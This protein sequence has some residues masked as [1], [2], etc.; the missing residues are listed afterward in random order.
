MTIRWLTVLLVVLWSLFVMKVEHGNAAQARGGPHAD[1]SA[2][3]TEILEQLQASVKA[4]AVGDLVTLQATSQPVDPVDECGSN[5]RYEFNRRVQANGVV[6]PFQIPSDQVLV[7]TNFDWV[8]SSPPNALH[9][10]NSLRTARLLRVDDSGGVNGSS[11]LSSAMSDAAGRAG[12]Y[13]TFPTGLVISSS[14][15]SPRHLCIQMM[16]PS[17]EEDVFATVQGFLFPSQ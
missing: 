9:Q 5:T 15:A 16:N 13:E 14:V 17:D 8:V 1:Q 4:E 6:L 2:I 10:P 12:S 3:L 11:A 7:V